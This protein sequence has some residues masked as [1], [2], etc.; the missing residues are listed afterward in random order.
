M[1]RSVRDVRLGVE[2]A[3]RRLGELLESGISFGVPERGRGEERGSGDTMGK[4]GS[5]VAIGSG[6]WL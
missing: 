3:S 1:P 6:L 2:V 5:V 4:T